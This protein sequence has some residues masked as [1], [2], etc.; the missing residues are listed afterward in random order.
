[1]A[2]G[3]FRPDGEVSTIEREALNYYNDFI[4]CKE[5]GWTPLELLEQPIDYIQQF[6]A[7]SGVQATVERSRQRVAQSRHKK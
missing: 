4:I 6:V 7:I 1:M 2:R 5:F 3:M